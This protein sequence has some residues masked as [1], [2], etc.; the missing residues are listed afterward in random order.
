MAAFPSLAMTSTPFC[1]SV[2]EP[3]TMYVL[4][5]MAASVGLDVEFESKERQSCDKIFG[6]MCLH[7]PTNVIGGGAHLRMREN[8][9]LMASVSKV[10]LDR[11]VE[12]REFEDVV[13]ELAIW[14]TE[15]SVTGPW[16]DAKGYR[17][18]LL[19]WDKLDDVLH[20]RHR[21][22]RRRLQ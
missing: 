14:V 11:C 4:A 2:Y 9:S 21:K 6:L 12:D 5:E 19:R 3:Q 7:W 16:T 15:Q 17:T 8:A 1:L 13:K 18:A 22:K 20:Q 10:I